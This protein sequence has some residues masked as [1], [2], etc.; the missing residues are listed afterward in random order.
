MNII[1]F[2]GESRSPLSSRPSPKGES[3][4]LDG[5]AGRRGASSRLGV[6]GRQRSAGRCVAARDDSGG[7]RPHPPSLRDGPSP[8]SCS[9]G[10]DCGRLFGDIVDTF[11]SGGGGAVQGQRPSMGTRICPLSHCS[12]GAD[13]RSPFPG[14]ERRVQHDR[15]RSMRNLVRGDGRVTMVCLTMTCGPAG[16]SLL[17]LPSPL[18]DFA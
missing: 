17:S 16:V 7:H 8:A 12:S 6:P 3:R 4:D 2:R 13:A 10:R 14:G 11:D 1:L 15:L 9:D 5:M 18:T